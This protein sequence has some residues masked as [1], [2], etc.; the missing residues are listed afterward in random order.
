MTRSMSIDVDVSVSCQ[1]RVRLQ[2][3]RYSLLRAR[4]FP[5]RR[6]LQHRLDLDKN[7]V[8]FE[9]QH[10]RWREREQFLRAH[11][12]SERLRGVCYR[13]GCTHLGEGVHRVGTGDGRSGHSHPVL[14]LAR[15]TRWWRGASADGGRWAALSRFV[16]FSTAQP[17][18]SHSRTDGLRHASVP[19]ENYSASAASLL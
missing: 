10:R 8:F 3:A 19:R 12:L 17:A 18:R 9:G 2:S 1:V 16:A 7:L 4:T 14:R 15:T 6:V 11:L 13:W 5:V